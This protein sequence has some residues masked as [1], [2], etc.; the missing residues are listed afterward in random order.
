VLRAGWLGFDSRQRQDISLLHSVQTGS[1]IHPASY[2]TGTGGAEADNRILSNAPPIYL[3]GVLLNN[4]TRG[5]LYFN[6]GCRQESKLLKLLMGSVFWDITTRRSA[7]NGL[8]IY[9]PTHLPTYL[10]T[11]TLTHLS[12]YGST[13]L[14][15]TLAA[16]PVS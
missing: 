11:Y 14:C 5:Q 16:F 3:H 10:P 12:I 1:R 9:L 2:L 7:F 13:A 15:W 4:Y 6:C 8:P